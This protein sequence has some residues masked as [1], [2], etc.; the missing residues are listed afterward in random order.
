LFGKAF[1]AT[2]GVGCAIVV[3]LVLL[4]VVASVCTAGLVSGLRAPTPPAVLVSAGR[5][6]TPAATATPPRS[7]V[8]VKQ[9]EGTGAKQ[10]ETFSVGDEWRVDWINSGSYLGVYL[11]DARTN[12]PVDV[13]VNTTKV[14]S[15]T[16]FLH[17]AGSYYLVINSSTRPVPGRSPCRI[18]ANDGYR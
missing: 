12:A 10:T 3:G 2:L 9:W 18:S 5:A 7:W 4:F 15:D 17:R 6:S 11:H 1:T 13:P 8:V 16:S 14:G